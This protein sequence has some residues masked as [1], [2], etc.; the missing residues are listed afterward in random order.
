MKLKLFLLATIAVFMNIS[1]MSAYDVR[2]YS[3]R[4][5]NYNV[6]LSSSNVKCITE[7]SYGFIWL[8]TKN[9][10]HRFDGI[11]T[12]RLRCYDYEKM[13]GNDNINALYEDKYKNLWVGTDRG[14]YR[15]NPVT[16]RF[17][18]MDIKDKK[19]GE[20]AN[21]WIQA[22]AGDGKGNVWALLPD[23]GVFR[24][25]NNDVSYYSVLPNN[26]S[27][28]EKFPSNLCVDRNGDAWVVTTGKGIYKYNKHTDRFDKVIAKDGET[29]DGKYF[30]QAS[31]DVD[32]TLIFASSNV[33]GIKRNV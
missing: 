14:I 23:V 8:G 18:F 13:Q 22:I 20:Y 25:H 17:S 31:E 15:Y 1:S 21:N 30:A 19:T 24:Y 29:L 2:H 33:R 12:R 32:G 27:F 16:D 4:H 11:G 9:G 10:L 6:G 3:F 5:V 28:K 26:G 7:D